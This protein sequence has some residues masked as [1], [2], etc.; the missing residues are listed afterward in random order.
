MAPVV[1]KFKSFMDRPEDV[2]R[3]ILEQLDSE[4]L[5]VF[6]TV[7]PARAYEKQKDI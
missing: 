5:I 6:P 1:E 2:A 4:R 7:K 3:G